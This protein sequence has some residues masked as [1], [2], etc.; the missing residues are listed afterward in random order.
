MMRLYLVGT[1]LLLV[2]VGVTSFWLLE[3]STERQLDVLTVN[4]IQEFRLRVAERISAQDLSA[5]DEESAEA[6]AV[7]P[8]DPSQLEQ[9]AREILARQS[10]PTAWRVWSIDD[11]AILVEAGR[12]DL[13]TPSAPSRDEAAFG[14]THE[15]ED[16]RRW[17]TEEIPHGLLVGVVLDASEQLEAL[18]RYQVLAGALM[19]LAA[20]VSLALGAYMVQRMRRMLR[21]VAESARAVQ[22]PTR[23]V[24]ELD[25]PDAPDEIR[26]VVDALR[27]LFGRVRAE[28]DRS[29]VFYASMAHELRSPIQNLVGATEVALFTGRDG[30][31]YR[32]VLESNLD[33]LR[34]L[35]DAID[36]LVTICSERRPGTSV[37]SEDFDLL[38]EARIRLARERA[39]AA[40][41]RVELHIEGEG[42]LSMRGD[43]EG[44]LRA[45]RNLAANAIQW[46]PPERDVEV[47]LSGHDDRIEVVVDDAGPGVPP[48]VR[49][50][51]FEPFA[52]GPVLDGQRMGY[53][54]GLAI[55]RA[56]VDAQG[57]EVEIG[58]SPAG[59]ARFR[60][61]LP[62]TA[63]SRA[64][65]RSGGAPPE[66][67]GK[68]G[69]PRPAG[70]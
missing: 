13:L 47:L 6:A 36:N 37:E 25:L 51:I 56:A 49:E 60:M 8:T 41:R 4:Q 19:V 46:S 65:A 55:V 33:E 1:T 7:S 16:N 27:E 45:L 53:G 38:D 61:R 21:R 40:R 54:L 32:G 29:R 5:G 63:R 10:V 67:A 23:E 48:E 58:R 18:R 68:G 57:G 42:D 66:P 34:D 22:E 44:L 35:G 30:A 52:R 50:H 28:A 11:R 31:D 14:V 59:G 62:R 15:A 70:D 17:R 64:G 69:D 43:R 2:A 20:M 24:V 26:D 9:M 39:Q 12:L 3:R